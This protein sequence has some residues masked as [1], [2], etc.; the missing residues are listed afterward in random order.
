MFFTTITFVVFKHL[1][2][3]N[4]H[5]NKGS[6]INQEIL[7]PKLLT[8]ITKSLANFSKE[9]EQVARDKGQAKHR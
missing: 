5:N 4:C 2:L 3:V 1:F 8:N 9:Y 7:N 6:S